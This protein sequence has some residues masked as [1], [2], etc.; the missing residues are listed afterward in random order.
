MTFDAELKDLAGRAA[1]AHVRSDG[2]ASLAVKA[3]VRRARRVYRA[4]VAVGTTA[5]VLAVGAVATAVVQR[6]PDAAPP[7]GTVA[8]TPDGTTVP[9]PGPDA[10]APAL[11]TDGVLAGWGDVGIDE[12][13]FGEFALA[14]SAS[15]GGRAVVVGC[16][17]SGVDV[18]GFPVWYADDAGTWVQAD[19]TRAGWEPGNGCL[20]DV[21]ASPH[22]YFA[23]AT[24]GFL[25]STDG[26]TWEVVADLPVDGPLYS[27]ALFALG[28]R[29]TVLFSRASYAEST[30]AE[31]WT[32]TDG[33]SWSQV[34]DGS[35]AV[36]DNGRVGDVLQ[37]GDVLVAVGASPGGAYVPTA[38]AWI[39]A[40]GLT[41]ERTTPSG[42][43]FADDAMTGVVAADGG[44]VAV[45]TCT[46]TNQMCSWRSDDGRTWVPEDVPA[47]DI[48]PSMAYLHALAVTAVGGDVYAIGTAYDPESSASGE[49]RLWH[50]APG[51]TWERVD[52]GV[53]GAVPFGQV[54]VGGRVVGFWPLG[55]GTGPAGAAR[56][57]TPLP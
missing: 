14:G 39:S 11:I 15:A 36:F 42:E 28:D 23:I 47:E 43:G 17:P 44:F 13:T 54:E 3:R 52:P 29:V 27:P 40:D 1:Q 37:V 55:A 2:F 8:P 26:S 38:A 5:A 21:V 25:R 12:R 24:F 34:T 4:T 30:V 6:W 9:T 18:G 56:V 53:V 31:L 16:G 45:G 57:L 20:M 51:G 10:T 48:D 46:D 7:A 41:W 32:T 49:L 50:R 35:A 22:G 33:V 19:G